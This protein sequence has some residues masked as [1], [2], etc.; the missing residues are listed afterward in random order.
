M[1]KTFL[2]VGGPTGDHETDMA[3]P[4]TAAVNT[5]PTFLGGD[6]TLAS[7][8]VSIAYDVVVQPDGRIVAVGTTFAGITRGTD[9]D[10]LRFNADGT[11]DTSFGAGGAVSTDFGAL[12]QAAS[13]ALQADGRIV[14]GGLSGNGFALARYT[15]AGTLD[16]T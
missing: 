3:A 13:V 16:T 5:A 8:D 10:V 12:D 15:A 6:G 14:V 7:F 2:S 9:F 11:V 1:N 4:G